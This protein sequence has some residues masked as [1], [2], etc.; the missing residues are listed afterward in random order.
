MDSPQQFEVPIRY[1][2][3]HYEPDDRLCVAL[4]KRQ[5][6]QSVIRQEFADAREICKPKYQAH[7]RAVNAQGADVYL[8]VNTIMPERRNRTKA[9]ID[10]VR[11]LFVDIDERGGE[12]VR[13]ILASDLPKPSAVIESSRDR[14]QVLWSV[15]GFE[16]DQAEAAV[17][18]IAT[19]FEA[20]QS[21]W[22]CARVLRLPGFRNTKREQ[23][24]YA[25]IIPGERSA[26]IL[27][28]KD[29]P[30]FPALERTVHVSKV[31]AVTG[32]SQ[33]GKDWA[34][35]LRSLERGVSPAVIA[36]DIE[37][38]RTGN[39]QNPHRYAERT[40]EKAVHVYERK[41]EGISSRRGMKEEVMNE[42]DNLKSAAQLTTEQLATETRELHAHYEQ[43]KERYE[44]APPGQRAEIREEMTPVVQRERE[45]RQEYT[46]RLKL[47]ITQDRVPEQGIGYS[48]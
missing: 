37:A 39:K 3:A 2:Q 31:N 20:D 8:S 14:F 46:G 5:E 40:V 10:Q 23:P 16:K 1:I 9:D 48:R 13:A 41:R 6:E 33:S 12:V 29:F 34:Y 42:R 30:E 18:S 15:D 7:L 28:P 11:H 36:E 38:F 26:H 17:R 44:Q 21:V 47:E 32:H 35:A 27:T 43:L 22:D 24:F 19:R 45:L 25:R 4:I